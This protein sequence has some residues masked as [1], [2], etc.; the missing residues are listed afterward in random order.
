M[1]EKITQFINE[2]LPNTASKIFAGISLVSAL[3]AAPAYLYNKNKQD[4]IDW[5]FEKA[6]T[7]V[8]ASVKTLTAAS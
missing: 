2:I 1:K 5:A 7:E 8:M 3:S 4:Q 6:K